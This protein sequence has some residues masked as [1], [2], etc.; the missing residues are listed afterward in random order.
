MAQLAKEVESDFVII[1]WCGH[2]RIE[3]ELDNPHVNPFGHI[4]PSGPRE[5]KHTSPAH[6]Y[7]VKDLCRRSPCSVGVFVDRGF[8]V[9]LAQPEEVLEDYTLADNTVAMKNQP[10]FPGWNQHIFVPFFGGADD[11][12]AVSFAIRLA[13]SP[14]LRVTIL[15]LTRT[16]APTSNDCNIE[17]LPM[18]PEN[19]APATPYRDKYYVGT[20]TRATLGESSLV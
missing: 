5:A 19:A 3:N 15:R 1:P 9:S 18:T 10:S 11:R 7:F 13:A 6:A 20:A 4:W 2:G 14:G 12:A 17:D 16:I 8:G